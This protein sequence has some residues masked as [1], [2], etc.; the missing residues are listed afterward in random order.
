[1]AMIVSG[2]G[3]TLN[4]EG[5]EVVEVTMAADHATGAEPRDHCSWHNYSIYQIGFTLLSTFYVED[6]NLCIFHSYA[7]D[8]PK[9]YYVPMDKYSGYLSLDNGQKLDKT[10]LKLLTQLCL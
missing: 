9:R 1:M 2:S 5:S 10:N 7:C 3:S 8:I 4:G 6:I